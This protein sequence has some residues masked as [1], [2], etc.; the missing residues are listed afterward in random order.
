MKASSKIGIVFV[1]VV[2]GFALSASATDIYFDLAPTGSNNGA[3][4][5]NARAYSSMT[6]TDYTP[7]NVLHICGTGTAALGATPITIQGSGA[8]G[9]PVTLKFET[10]AVLQSPRFGSAT[11]GAITCSGKHDIVIDGGTNGI[12]Q[13][14]ANGSALANHAASM[15]IYT[16]NCT[17]VEVKNLAIQ[18]IYVNTDTTGAGSTNTG[19]IYFQGKSTNNK[20]HDS[21]VNDARTGV[22]VDFD[23]GG[24]ASNVQIYNNQ[25]GHHPWGINFGA[26]NASSTATNVVIHD[27]EFFD[28]NSWATTSYHTD[29]IILYN[30]ADGGYTCSGLAPVDTYTIY[31]NYFH[32]T[33]GNGC[34]DC[35]TGHIA[36]GERSACT[37]YNNVMVDDNAYTCNGYVWLYAVGGPNYVYNNTIVGGSASNNVAYNLNASLGNS[38]KS[39]TAFYDNVTT[40]VGYAITD[41]NGSSITA[42]IIAS[43]NNI[44]NRTSGPPQFEYNFGGSPTF[45]SYTTWTGS[46]GFDSHGSSNAPNLDGNY[47][48]Q[49]GSPAIGLG[50]NLTSLGIPSLDLDRVG[51][52]RPAS[53]PWDAGAYDASGATAINPPSA[54]TAVVH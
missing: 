11:S 33:L 46:Y 45:V 19:D 10:G 40:G 35:P 41:Y 17:N 14:T 42:D 48:P 50:A 15:G 7:G 28:W 31:N 52:A 39:H 27:N 8:S 3:N 12:I 20:V 25:I 43:D 2:M 30:D 18:H 16:S 1:F 47:K 24:D 23:S 32:G 36:C 49:T 38:T 29:G 54:L 26:C 9:N 22:W 53:G 44:W 51:V 13:N 5:A 6:S 21:T 34:P 37:V 4:C